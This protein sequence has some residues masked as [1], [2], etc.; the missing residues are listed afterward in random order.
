MGEALRLRDVLLRRGERVVL[1][2]LDLEA[3]RG[4]F[5]GVIGP[6][7]AGKTTLLE[8]MA[9]SHPYTGSLRVLEQEVGGLSAAGRSRLRTRIG[10]VPQ[11]SA[12][13][14]VVPLC[15]REVVAIGRTGRAGPFHALSARDREICHHWMEQLGLLEL[16]GRS[17]LRLSGG[18]RSKVHLARA[19]AQE[20][21][22]LL[23]D[24]P[25]GHLDLRWQEEMTELVRRLWRS[26]GLTVVMVTHE[27]RHL[28]AGCDHL[29]LLGQGRLLGSGR[30]ESVLGLSGDIRLMNDTA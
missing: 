27:L 24:E 2:G 13:T 16:A 22:L 29:V 3:A 23:L 6:N 21:E 20:P 28:P 7:G 5:L 18:E 26:T 11:M 14:P 25:A 30:A 8:A 1:R 12:E 17:Y 10:F 9:G 15:V 19:L 4:D